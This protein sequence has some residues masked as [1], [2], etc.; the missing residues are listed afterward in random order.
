VLDL[1]Q[2]VRI[3]ARS[4]VRRPGFA[5]V[6]LVTIALAMGGLTTIFTVLRGTLLE[7]L[8]YGASDRLVTLDVVSRQGFYISTSIPNYRDWARSEAFDRVAAGADW[9]M[10]LTGD[11]PA[12]VVSLGA[13]IGDLWGTLG[14]TAFLGRLFDPAETEPGAPPVIVLG[15]DFW[16]THFAADRRVIGQT[17]VL[18]DRPHTIIG[19]APPGFSFPSPGVDGYVPMG[20]IPDLPFDDRESSFGTRVFARLASGTSPDAA[21]EDLTRISASVTAE[22]GLE[23]AT[24]EIR[25]LREYVVGDLGPSLWILFGA[26]L[27][28]L[29]IATANVANLTLARGEDRRQ[30]V[31]VRTALGA[32]RGTV[33]RG[34]LL[35]SLLLSL[36]GGAVGAL[37]ALIGLRLVTP[38]L[39]E[40]TATAGGRIGLDGTVLAFTF[41]VALASGLLFGAIPALRAS[42]TDLTAD[43]KQ[44]ARGATRGDRGLRSALVVAEVALSMVLLVGA[45]LMIRSL[46]ELRHVDKGFEAGGRLTGRV[47]VGREDHPTAEAWRGFLGDLERRA[48]ALPGVRAAALTLLLP[49]SDRSWERRIFPEGVPVEGDG[50]SFLYGVVSN[51]YFEA[52]GIPI[53]RGRAFTDADREGVDPVTIIDETMAE[54]F[55][56]GENPLGKRVTFE[57]TGTHEEPVPVYRTIVGVARNVRHYEL[58]EPSRIQAYIPYRQSGTQWGMDMYV[59][60]ATSV[61]PEELVAPLRAEVAGLDPDVP[62]FSV[63]ALG[64]YVDDAVRGDRTLGRILATFSGL[65]LLLAGI[66]IFGVLSYTVARRRREIGIR[67]ALGAD[68]SSVRRWVARDG[69]VLGGV[70]VTIGLAAAAVLTRILRGFLYGVSPVDPVV[71][72]GLALFLLVV[73]LVA[74]YGPAARAT[75]VDPAEV[76]RREN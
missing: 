36:A 63:R 8:P 64:S 10:T 76:L 16:S 62:L 71:Y 27:F 35:E 61:P 54:R 70:G 59:V 66:G 15:H 32:G 9:G 57:F 73:V 20:S 67:M 49:L 28:V 26:V 48:S 5:A 4:L 60:L 43:L 41:G 75:R 2:D 7:P 69:L 21:L 33:V 38:L 40:V 18:D 51:D 6:A 50:D 12:E 11:G 34:L 23:M 52:L 56:P 30:E 13:V 68:A 14:T 74:T 3:A 44:G 53:L 58:E 37:L 24:P 39:P 55:W 46:G 47:S 17:I 45:G 31:A 42:R 29:L 1:L 22:E 65:A 72:G 25:S 19:V